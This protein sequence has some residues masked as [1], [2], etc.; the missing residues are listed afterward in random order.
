VGADNANHAAHDVQAAYAN[1]YYACMHE[2]GQQAA[3]DGQPPPPGY[4]Y[5]PP[6]PGYGR[7]PYAPAA[8]SY[9][10]P[11]SPITVAPGTV[12]QLRTA[13]SVDSKRAKEGTGLD[14]TVIRDVTVNGYLAIP[15]GATVHGVISQV[16]HAGE[17]TGTPELALQ[18]T[19][20]ELKGVQYPIDSDQFRVKGPSKT[21]RTVGNAIGG[22]LLGTIIGGAAGGGGGAAI[23]AVAGGTAGTALS[24]AGSPR[25][26]IP[27][28]ALVTFHL[29][30]PLTLDPVSREEA[31]R[32]AQGLYPGGPALYRRGPGP[33]YYA[34]PAP[35]GYPPV[36]YRP[37]YMAG[38]GYYY[39]R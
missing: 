39:W 30:T 15:R 37:Y 38:G 32:L 4:G 22:A 11:R 29:N 35:Y 7:Q 6:P 27:A 36:Y 10:L 13:D 31:M 26:W 33:G 16:K 23:G 2:D 14:F 5:P 17:L 28:E 34:Y 25:A 8:P 20:L 9:S 12:L 24:A 18:I 3:Y 1:A 19:S 21:G